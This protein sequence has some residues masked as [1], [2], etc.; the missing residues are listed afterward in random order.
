MGPFELAVIEVL[1]VLLLDIFSVAGTCHELTSHA[2]S[3][4]LAGF[5]NREL[6]SVGVIRKDQVTL[7]PFNL[8]LGK[9]LPLALAHNQ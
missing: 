1:D 2:L 8:L 7:Y 3:M 9:G 4:T 6:L 5:I